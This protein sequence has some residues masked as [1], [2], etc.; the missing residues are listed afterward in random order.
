MIWRWSRRSWG[1]LR[2][3]GTTF[4]GSWNMSI[5]LL[6]TSNTMTIRLLETICLLIRSRGQ[7]VHRILWRSSRKIRSFMR[8]WKN[9]R[10]SCNKKKK[11]RKDDM[12][13][14]R[15]SWKKSSRRRS[16]KRRQRRN[17][18][19]CRIW[20]KSR[21]GWIIGSRTWG[22]GR[23]TITRLYLVPLFLREYRNNRN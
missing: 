7:Q 3:R 2:G 18:K 22:R 23:R 9:R 15:R 14:R 13:K 8:K 21:T 20:R 11:L 16:R 6:R 4:R 5:S 1:W 12:S 17:S 19:Y 10:G